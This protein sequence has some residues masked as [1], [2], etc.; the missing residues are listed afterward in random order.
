MQ[1]KARQFLQIAIVLSLGYVEAEAGLINRGNGLI[2]DDVLQ[3]TWLQDASYAF[4]LGHGTSDNGRMT[5]QSARSWAAGLSYAG[6]D[7]WRLPTVR[8][9]DN[10]AMDPVFSNNATTDKGYARTGAAGG[11][12]NNQGDPVSELGHMYYVNRP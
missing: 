5:W 9:I 12:R 11:W 7:D 6:F 1:G 10:V 3:I 8:P 2:Y 4:T